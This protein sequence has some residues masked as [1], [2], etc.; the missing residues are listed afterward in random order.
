MGSILSMI[1]SRF[2]KLA[3]WLTRCLEPVRKK[4]APYS[5]KDSFE[6][7]QQLDNLN[8]SNK[9][10]VQFDVSSPFIKIPLEET[11]DIIDKHLNCLLF[12]EINSNSFCS[13]EPKIHIFI[14]TVC[15]TA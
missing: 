13:Y 12:I 14:S 7:A 11:T 8:V 3:R 2:Y 15:C 10:M 5:L 9:F 1:G 6:F 4:I